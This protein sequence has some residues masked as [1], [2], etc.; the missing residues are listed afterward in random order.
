MRDMRDSRRRFLQLG[1]GLISGGVAGCSGRNS[2]AEKN[3]SPT[4]TA[5]PESTPTQVGTPF[6]V[7]FEFDVEVVN[8]Q[9][10]SDDPPLVRITVTNEDDE[11]HNLGTSSHEF[12]FTAASDTRDGATLVLLWDWGDRGED[13]WAGT[14]KSQPAYNGTTIGPGGSTS[15]RRAVM[16]GAE[17]YSGPPETCWPRNTFLFT[18]SYALDSSEPGAYDGETFN[19]GFW[20]RITEGPRI[21]TWAIQPFQ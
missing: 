8:R 7:P 6:S 11:P 12:P 10:T 4:Q 1:A 13:C 16:N 21:E 18:E 20:V 15:A 17:G 2:P 5:T 3:N 14:P 9:P 19:W